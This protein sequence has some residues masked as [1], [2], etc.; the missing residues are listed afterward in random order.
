MYSSNRTLRTGKER[1]LPKYTYCTRYSTGTVPGTGI[2]HTAYS[3]LQS[4][5]LG[6]IVV[7]I[8]IFMRKCYT[9]HI[10]Q[11]RFFLNP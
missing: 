9:P 10:P 2:Y 3:N 4:S 1:W 8:F 6:K 7:V 5:T 11:P